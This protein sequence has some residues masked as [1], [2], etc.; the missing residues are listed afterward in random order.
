MNRII[1]V[2]SKAA[3]EPGTPSIVIAVV[4]TLS[5]FVIPIRVMAQVL[6]DPPTPYHFLRY[7]DAPDDQKSPAW[8]DDFWE[9]LK[10]VPLGLEQIGRAHV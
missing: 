1:K 5:L 3:A 2:C 7:D 10:F 6:R 8:P 9:P 4:I